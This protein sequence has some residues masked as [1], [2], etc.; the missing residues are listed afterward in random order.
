M[1]KVRVYELAK[2]LGVES[3]TLMAE[4]E[5]MGEFVRTAS[6]TLE[7]PLVQRMRGALLPAAIRSAVIARRFED[8]EQKL[9]ALRKVD[10]TEG[11]SL[12]REVGE[13]IA[14]RRSQGGAG[15]RRIEWLTGL[16]AM[17]DVATRSGYQPQPASSDPRSGPGPVTPPAA[18]SGPPRSHLG[19][20]TP[21]PGRQR[22]E[23]LGR[24][25]ED[26]FVG[27][28]ETLF[29][30]SDQERVRVRKQSSGTQFG[31]DIEFDA[32]DARTGTVRCHVECKNY[33][34][35]VSLPD[36]APKLLQQ[37]V[38]WENKELDYFIVISP[39]AGATNELSRLVQD[40]NDSGKFQFKVLLWDADSGV[41]ELFRLS[42]G[43][44][45]EI[46]QRPAPKHSEQERAGIARRWMARLRPLARVPSAWRKYLTT[47]SMHELYTES[48]FRDVRQDAIALGALT[49]SGGPLPG[50]LAGHV[51][52]WLTSRPERTLLLLGEFGDGKS[53][54]TYDLGLQ[55]AAEF[56][57][58]PADGW[59]CLRIP[60]RSL[61]ED[62]S[63]QA[64]LRRRLEDIGVSMAEWV[65]VTR[66]HKT[67]V[68]LDGFDE[69]S[70]KLDPRTLEEN[71]G[72]LARCVEC[73]PGAKVLVSSRTHFFEH[74]S[75]YKQFLLTLGTPR[76]LRVAPIPLQERLAHLE[77]YAARTG[78]EAK[79]AKLKTL[80]DPIGLAAKPLFLQMIEHT[81]PGLPT[82]RFNEVVLYEQYVDDSL[83]RKARDLQPGN[84]LD[85][86]RLIGN[87]KVILEELAVRLHRSSTDYVNLRDFDTGRRE[88]LPEML[89]AMSGATSPAMS[90]GDPSA[91][92]PDARSRVGVRSLL[93]PV[94]GADPDG[95]PVDFF[96][97]SMRE[98][99][100][101][102]AL[103]RA[104]ASEGENA[105]ALLSSVPLQPEIVDFSRLLIQHPSDV[106]GTDTQETFTH[107]LASLARSATRPLWDGRYLGGNAVTL[108]FALNRRLPHAD[109]SDL[110]LDYAD[111]AGADLSGVSFKGSSLRGA[112]LDNVRMTDTDLRGADLT[113][114]QLEQTEP[115]TALAFEADSNTAYAAYKDRSIRRWT[116]GTGGR[117]NCTTLAELS[118]QPE[119]LELSPFGDVIVTGVQEIGILS[120][121]DADG[122]WEMAARFPKGPDLDLESVD[123]NNVT[124]RVRR[125]GK[126]LVLVTYDPATR[127]LR[128]RAVVP[129]ADNSG[130]LFLLGGGVTLEAA[131]GGIVLT[132]G[133]DQC[134]F[135]VPGMTCSAVR[136]L[137]DEEALLAAGHEDGMVSLWHLRSLLSQPT[138]DRIWQHRVH[139]GSVTDVRASGMFVLSGGMDRTICLFALG[140]GWLTS[141]P[142][143]LHRTLECTGMRISGVRG[144]KEYAM[145][146]SL[147]SDPTT[148]P[149]ASRRT[150]RA[151]QGPRGR[152]A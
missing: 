44:Y 147:L 99:F 67:L 95:W 131:G 28:L 22:P 46:Y 66:D 33:T 84:R 143:R 1:A 43:L 122:G 98:F 139:A 5:K 15:I 96:H 88:G 91:S 151:R 128:E 89:W 73:F 13:L 47:S 6:S 115:I 97:R 64:A 27:I 52:E 50:T 60:L 62:R 23:M 93:K 17:H 68:I 130:E 102:R 105:K 125:A 21:H 20:V 113:G 58:D 148:G 30:L 71:I 77:A 126:P 100:V 129:T 146:A 4:L 35:A 118:F 63:P 54:F 37:Y 108:L 83:K 40:C 134:C 70:A 116:L 59:T 16:W 72:A 39:R 92:T 107:K 2:E 36:I 32:T 136:Q 65:E 94:A 103:V 12:L 132:V 90:P 31:H 8:A 45:R 137:S 101:A 142:M 3:K 110:A 14:Q 74:I 79:L 111:L 9:A 25:L 80:Y 48:D 138:L 120:P 85:E 112:S 140:N 106:T 11:G 145:L 69:M 152:R 121:R 55:L 34:H 78:Q 29:R 141:E 75:D 49:E 24:E 41:E 56:L 135:A 61:Q 87:L 7:A 18:R 81:L 53:F 119:R 123:G 109:W 82:D 104:L 144:P 57:D 133:D 19:A 51:R 86:G 114:V 42:P 10:R 149:Q 76:L 117:T 150:P 124:L 127:T 26:G 38:Y